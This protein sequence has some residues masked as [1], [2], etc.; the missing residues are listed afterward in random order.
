MNINIR[1]THSFFPGGASDDFAKAKAYIPFAATI[2]LPP[3]HEDLSNDGFKIDA[4]KIRGVGEE[5]WAAMTEVAL[6]ASLEILG[7]DKSSR[8]EEKLRREGSRVQAQQREG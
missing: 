8:L 1:S 6:A 3:S 7:P 5:M 2:E 4:S